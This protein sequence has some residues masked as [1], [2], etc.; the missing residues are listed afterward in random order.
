MQWTLTPDWSELK[1]LDHT[2]TGFQTDLVV[3]QAGT[4]E[5]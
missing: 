2:D 3:R 5:E 4:E 1:G